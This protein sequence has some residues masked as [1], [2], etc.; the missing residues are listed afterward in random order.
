MSK[1]GNQIVKF[2]DLPAELERSI[3]GWS[4]EVT[5]EAYKLLDECGEGMLADIKSTNV[6]GEGWAVQ[7]LGIRK[8]QTRWTRRVANKEKPSLVHLY[9]FG[10]TTRFG[11]GRQGAGW[12]DKRHMKERVEARPSVLPAYYKWMDIFSA[13]LNKIIGK[14]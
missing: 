5:K 1:S 6:Q 14:G 4:G 9:E 7:K 2:Q 12:P 10:H 3:M 11:T 8:T 13:G